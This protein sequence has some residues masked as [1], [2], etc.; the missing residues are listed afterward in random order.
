MNELADETVFSAARAASPRLLGRYCGHGGGRLRAGRDR[1]RPGLRCAAPHGA[2]RRRRH[3]RGR[4]V[5][6]GVSALTGRSSGRRLRPEAGPI[7]PISRRKGT[8]I[9][10]VATPR[11]L[12]SPA[13][14]ARTRIVLG[15]S[16]YARKPSPCRSSPGSRAGV[17]G[18]R[19]PPRSAG[20]T[21][22]PQASAER[23]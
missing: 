21:R 3:G 6:G 10:M 2:P 23:L 18:G 17:R 5:R 19:R 14:S 15:R 11:P 9:M 1:C 13:I 7:S 12:V 16:T 22:R 4:T 20:P 8:E